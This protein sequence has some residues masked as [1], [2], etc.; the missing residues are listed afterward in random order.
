MCVCAYCNEETTRQSINQCNLGSRV[1]RTLVRIYVD[2]L[3]LW[4]GG[5]LGLVINMRLTWM[6]HM[7]SRLPVTDK[8]APDK[9]A[10]CWGMKRGRLYSNIPPSSILDLPLSRSALLWLS[11]CVS[12]RRVSQF[13]RFVYT[14]RKLVACLG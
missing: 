11:I 9:P 1:W 2:Y 7:T 3:L 4:M 13:W 12:G 6:R 8:A 14:A 5:S 10:L